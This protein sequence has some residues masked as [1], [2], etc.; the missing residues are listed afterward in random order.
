MYAQH[1]QAFNVKLPVAFRVT[2]NKEKKGMTHFLS[3]HKLQILDDF[4]LQV[5][6]TRFVRILLAAAA[7]PAASCQTLRPCSSRVVSIPHDHAEDV[8]ASRHAVETVT[9]QRTLQPGA[10]R[11]QTIW[12]HSDVDVT[13]RRSAF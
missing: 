3:G 13:T 12:D 8:P 10:Y 11:R 1:G 5:E 7:A 9:F 4:P 2:L 6:L